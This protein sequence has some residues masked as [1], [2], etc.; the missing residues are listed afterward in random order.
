MTTFSLQESP[1]NHILSYC[2]LLSYCI[3]LGYERLILPGFLALGRFR[4]ASML[5][6]SS[7]AFH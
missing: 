6:D 2:V 5:L 1:A 7:W 4:Q 3:L